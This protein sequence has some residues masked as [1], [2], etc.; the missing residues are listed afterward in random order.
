VLLRGPDGRALEGLPMD[1]RTSSWLQ[2]VVKH[3]HGDE[4]YEMEERT[5]APSDNDPERGWE[6]G[7]IFYCKPC[8]EEIK[9]QPKPERK[10]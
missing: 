6:H 2:T 9:V 1:M 8:D 10:R 7:R 5:P 4:G 3:R